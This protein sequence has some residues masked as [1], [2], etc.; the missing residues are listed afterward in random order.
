MGKD[1]KRERAPVKSRAWSCSELVESHKELVAAKLEREDDDELH[2]GGTL[3]GMFR[4][5]ARHM[6]RSLQS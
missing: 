1:Q 4:V 2:Q 5:C 6:K 3:H